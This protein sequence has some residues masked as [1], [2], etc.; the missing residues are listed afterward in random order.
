MPPKW[1]TR[2]TA[3]Q[4]RNWYGGAGSV[5]LDTTVERA[6]A[7]APA[8]QVV[9]V[10]RESASPGRDALMGAY[11]ERVA[12][13]GGFRRSEADKSRD[14]RTGLTDEGTWRKAFPG[15]PQSQSRGI[16]DY[17][18]AAR[19]ALY[20][21]GNTT[22]EQMKQFR[23]QDPLF[24]RAGREAQGANMLGELR[25]EALKDYYN[26]NKRAAYESFQRRGIAGVSPTSG[27]PFIPQATA[28]SGFGV[29]PDM[30]GIRA[31]VASP[32]GRFI[33]SSRY[34]YGYSTRGPAQVAAQPSPASASAPATN[35]QQKAMAE[36][37]ELAV[38]GSPL[39]KRFVEEY[40]GYQKYDPSFFSNE[41]WPVELARRLAAPAGRPV[42]ATPKDA[43]DAE[44]L[45][46][47]GLSAGVEGVFP[48]SPADAANRRA[49]EWLAGKT[50]R[51]SKE[52]RA[53]IPI[54]FR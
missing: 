24:Q 41:Q 40:R 20:G 30:R 32:D 14:I 8:P 31:A 23:D 17:W 15:A 36:F 47:V 26:M 51:G 3:E 13:Y 34:G 35:W 39:N 21:P 27:L 19:N 33:E 1:P 45:K 9:M 53:S 54:S 28:G 49:A 2:M 7:A 38:E 48:L 44:M 42:A 4:K 18:V 11:A 37:P 12:G 10:G 16:N 50:T 25:L 43:A 22:P 5:P 6:A 29:A 46:R 52:G